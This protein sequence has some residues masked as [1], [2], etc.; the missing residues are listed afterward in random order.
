MRGRKREKNRRC[1]KLIFDK[2]KIKIGKIEQENYPNQYA[3]V[4]FLVGGNLG[5][6]SGKF[7]FAKEW[8]MKSMN[9]ATCKNLGDYVART[10][11]KTADLYNI[12]NEMNKALSLINQYVTLE[13]DVTTIHA[14]RYEVYLMGVLGETYRRLRMFREAEYC[15]GQVYE[16]SIIKN[17][18]GWKPHALLGKA[19]LSLQDNN[20]DKADALLREA[21]SIYTKT[22]QCW[23]RINTESILLAYMKNMIN[24]IEISLDKV[25]QEAKDLQYEYNVSVLNQ[26]KNNQTIQD[27]YLFFL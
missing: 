8:L 7:D 11:R 17:L 26:I 19:L 24:K 4:L 13:T 20:F 15:Y 2:K 21:L 14:S 1:Y 25:L 3:E 6:L 23:G 16:A 27:F 22:N 10:V 5:I 12:N 18:P 9:F